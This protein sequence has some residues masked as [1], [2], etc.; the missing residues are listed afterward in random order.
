[1]LEVGG[2]MNYPR[3]LACVVFNDARIVR[4]FVLHLSS[5]KETIRI[6]Q[7][8]RGDGGVLYT[9]ASVFIP[10]IFFWGGGDSH[11]QKT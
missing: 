2:T 6:L 3:A 10:G 8:R 9:A 4:R 11:P 5:T 7:R 1:M